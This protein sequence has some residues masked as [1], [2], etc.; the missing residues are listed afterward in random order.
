MIY[1]QTVLLLMLHVNLPAT[2][3]F[4][5]INVKLCLGGLPYTRPDPY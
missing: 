4:H 5:L 1:R 3:Y 2:Q